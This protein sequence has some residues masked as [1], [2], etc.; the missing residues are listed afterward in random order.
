MNLIIGLYLIVLGKTIFEKYAVMEKSL[1]NR[2][3][4]DNPSLRLISLISIFLQ[5]RYN[6]IMMIKHL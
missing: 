1:L 2:T 6:N 3:Q 5:I 4:E